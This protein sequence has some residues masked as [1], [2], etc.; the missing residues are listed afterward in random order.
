MHIHIEAN[1]G[2]FLP[3]PFE[4]VECLEFF[5]VMHEQTYIHTHTPSYTHTQKQNQKMNMG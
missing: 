4:Y 3:F 2:N 1:L 5:N